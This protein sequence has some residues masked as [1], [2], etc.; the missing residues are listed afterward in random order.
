MKKNLPILRF[1]K[2]IIII[3]LLLLIACLIPLSRI[4]VNPDLE[5][6]MP[7]TMESKIS[8]KLIAEHFSN[9]EML[10]L[11][12]ETDDILKTNTLNRMEKI[13]RAFEASPLLAK[14]YSLFQVKE[15]S[16]EAG[17]MTVVPLIDDIPENEDDIKQLRSKIRNNDLAYGL[18]VS[19]DFRMAMMVLTREKGLN[20]DTLLTFIRQTLEQFPGNEEVFIAGQPVLRA[21]AN[22]KISRDILILLPAG[23][24]I[25]LLLLWLSF[26]DIKLV[27]LPFSIVI[28]SM[29]VALALI[30]LFGWELSLIGI[31][32]PVM[33]IAIA[34]NYGIHFVAGYQEIQSLHPLRKHPKIIQT[35]INNLQKPVLLCGLT[36]IAGVLGLLAH[37]FMPARQMGIVSSIAIGFALLLSLTFLPAMLS[38]FQQFNK[39]KEIAVSKSGLIEK[40]LKWSAETTTKHPKIVIMVFVS[41]FLLLGAGIFNMRIAPD[42]NKVLPE[43]H[44]MNQAIQRADKHFGGSKQLSVMFVGEVTDPQLLKQIDS[45]GIVLKNHPLIGNT[46]SLA[47]MIR[48]MS[49]AMNDPGT[50]DY[51]KIPDNREAIAQYLELYAMSADLS[52]FEQFL[53]F[54]YQHTL[55][56][57]QYQSKSLS[58][59]EEIMQFVKNT[60]QSVKAP[61]TIGGMSLIDKEIS[62]SVKTGQVYSLL[63]ALGAIILLLSIIFRHAGAGITGSIP[64]MFAV[65]ATFGFMGWTGIELNIVT[66]LLS[67]VSIGLGVDFSI[68]LFWRI[69]REMMQSSSSATAISRAITGAGRGISINAFSVMIGFSVLFLSS[70][71]FIRSFALL[72]ILSLFFCLISALIL[73]PAICMLFKPTF[74]LKKKI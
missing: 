64:L 12:I 67:S 22:E 61:Y 56:S 44:F 34:N 25:M 23:L 54:D 24:I 28:I 26:R 5:S 16:S 58:D 73:I 32:I 62:E 42:S 70:F 52:D 3:T 36:T 68:H 37:L 41:A 19:D 33:M 57:V 17:M 65:T 35:L 55:L 18:V 74:L 2:P 59:S 53:S 1:H 27:M 46:T 6:Y 39:K 10:M 51:D 69:K 21:E 60:L 4:R 48:K 31:L 15:I 14:V 63:A 45:V 30:P 9:D 71:T 66:A 7:E 38:F 8:N 11:I 72:I 43:K 50:P 49:M 20:D 13:S 47:T 40:S 29:I